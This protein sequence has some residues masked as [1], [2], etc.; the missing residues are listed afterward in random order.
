MVTAA[1]KTLL[2]AG[3]SLF[4]LNISCN[5]VVISDWVYYKVQ[6]SKRGGGGGISRDGCNR[7]RDLIYF[8]M[9]NIVLGLTQTFTLPSKI[10]PA[11]KCSFR[12]KNASALRILNVQVLIIACHGH[13]PWFL[14]IFQWKKK[15]NTL[16]YGCTKLSITAMHYGWPPA[17][18]CGLFSCGFLWI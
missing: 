4:D 13:L 6:P 18:D 12:R 2:Q 15:Q 8:I 5:R 3:W 10:C 11:C 14:L 9:V 17:F 16:W 1:I 7:K